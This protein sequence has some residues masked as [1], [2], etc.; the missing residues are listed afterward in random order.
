MAK[1]EF[2]YNFNTFMFFVVALFVSTMKDL[3]KMRRD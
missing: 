1:Q 3:K 2:N